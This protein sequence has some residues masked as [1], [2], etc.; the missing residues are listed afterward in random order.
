MTKLEKLQAKLE[1]TKDLYR[2]VGL[3]C[4]G[5]AKAGAWIQLKNAQRRS[6]SLSGQIMKLEAEIKALAAIG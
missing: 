5:C 2:V 1:S 6:L 3:E 4:E